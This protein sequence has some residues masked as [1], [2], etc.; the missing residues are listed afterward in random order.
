MRV[1]RLQA[2]NVKRL[3]AVDI[4]VGEDEPVVVITGKNAAGK[5]SVLDA[6]WYALGGKDAA[7]SKP[8]REGERS[9]S[10][11]LDLGK[12]VVERRFLSDDRSRLEVRAPDGATYQSPQTLLDS[13]LG[14]LTFD[15]LE[16]ARQGRKEQRETLLRAMGVTVDDLDA[17]RKELFDERTGIGREVRAAKVQLDEA[18][19]PEGELPEREIDVS[20]IH[21]RITEA[22]LAER[23]HEQAVERRSSLLARREELLAEVADLERR[24]GELRARA[25]NQQAAADTLDAQIAAHAAPDLAAMEA[26]LV[27]A[28]ETNAAVQRRR[29]FRKQLDRLKR[30]EAA[31]DD[32]TNQIAHV[33]L[34]KEARLARA[35]LP[36]AGLGLDDE[37]VTYNGLPFD[38][39]SSAEQLRVSM[40]A[41]MAANP[42]LRVIRIGDGSLLD[43]ASMEIVRQMAVDGDWQIWCERVDE[44]GRVG[45]Y[46]EDGEVAADNRGA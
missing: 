45:V 40:A 19:R 27:A 9:A 33:D 22:K 3:R 13:L 10:V 35:G 14:E 23:A 26:E 46:I 29:E 18:D 5:S 20:G 42:E 17:R 32:L 2:E 4:S 12:F 11:T 37:G 44:T 39:L 21:A 7:P 38:Q 34:E 16:F 1:V 8:I 6:I 30:T 41:A 31:W 36:L 25:E 15:P 43:S 24:I 28:A